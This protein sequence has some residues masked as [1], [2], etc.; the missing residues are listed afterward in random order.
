MRWK[1]SILHHE[2]FVAHLYNAEAGTLRVAVLPRLSVWFRDWLVCRAWLVWLPCLAG[3]VEYLGARVANVGRMAGRLSRPSEE[4]V[5]LKI[6]GRHAHCEKITARKWKRLSIGQK[7]RSR[8]SYS[9]VCV[10]FV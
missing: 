10:E 5:M 6:A 4:N 8:Q 1:M 7:G 2:R 9:D 3:R